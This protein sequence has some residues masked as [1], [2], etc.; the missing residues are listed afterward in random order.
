[1]FYPLYYEEDHKKKKLFTYIVNVFPLRNK[2]LF[3]IFHK[4]YRKKSAI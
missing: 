4:N 2:Q 1:M 3:T